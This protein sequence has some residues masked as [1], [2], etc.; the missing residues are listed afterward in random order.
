MV[1][2]SQFGDYLRGRQNLGSP[3]QLYPNTMIL[4]AMMMMMMMFSLVMIMM[5][6]MMMTMMM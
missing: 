1:L 2:L 5:M 6:M 3:P 4:I